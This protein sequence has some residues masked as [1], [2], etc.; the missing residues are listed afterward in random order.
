[1]EGCVYA[2]HLME[3]SQRSSSI[4]M[5]FKAKKHGIPFWKKGLRPAFDHAGLSFENFGQLSHVTVRSMSALSAMPIIHEDIIKSVKWKRVAMIIIPF[6]KQRRVDGVLE[7]T[8]T[9]FR[10]INQRVLQH[11]PCSV[12][13]LADRGLGGGTH[14]S[15]SCVFSSVTV[16]FFGG[17]DDREALIYGVRMT[18]HPGIIL[19]VIRFFLELKPI[20]ETV[21]I[22]LNNDLKLSGMVD[23][24]V[25]SEVQEKILKDGSVVYE[26]RSV[27]DLAEIVAII[28]EYSNCSL[29]VVGRRP[30]GEVAAVLIK[31][32]ECE[33]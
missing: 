10:C 31:R 29:F 3:I 18:E 24:N 22:D 23:E 9:D 27:N 28:Q 4:L 32:G 33:K 15:A 26:E 12:G 1:M 11:A 7:P 17:R 13:I 30:E 20:Q 6:R 8:H 19:R 5:V 2:M 21:V 16:F 14:E 25:L